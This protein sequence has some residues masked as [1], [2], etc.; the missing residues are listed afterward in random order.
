MATKLSARLMVP[1]AGVTGVGTEDGMVE[2]TYAVRSTAWNISVF[3]HGE[4]ET[5]AWEAVSIK[6]V[7]T[8]VDG[9]VEFMSVITSHSDSARKTVEEAV[10]DMHAAIWLACERGAR[11]VRGDVPA[12]PEMLGADPM[13]DE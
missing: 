4:N 7:R 6:P 5:D 1:G 13:G 11:V 8:V 10:R 12:A 2:V 3:G 9:K